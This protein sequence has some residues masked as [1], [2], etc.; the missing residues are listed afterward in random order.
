MNVF[1]VVAVLF[2]MPVVAFAQ[3][4]PSPSVQSE[5]TAVQEAIA[6][7]KGATAIIVHT[8]DSAA[9]AYKKVARSL[10]AS[11]F[12]LN[13][14]DEALGYI[15][16][17]AR[18]APRYNM[19]YTCSVS[20]QRAQQGTTVTMYG[21]FSLPGAAAVSPIMAGESTI[22]YRGGPNS[23]YMICWNALQKALA[24]AYPNATTGY[25]RQ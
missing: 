4:H 13:K 1:R 6:P 18:Q 9:V 21:A 7:F 17:A 20:I 11:G 24:V 15:S 16:T 12:S 10:L 19:L 23:T 2:L 14:T 8:T 3:M 25:V 5:S 22:E